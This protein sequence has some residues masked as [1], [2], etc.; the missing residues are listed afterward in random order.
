YLADRGFEKVRGSLTRRPVVR[1]SDPADPNG[2]PVEQRLR[3]KK[4]NSLPADFDPAGSHDP[5][6]KIELAREFRAAVGELD[7][8]DLERAI[9]E[10]HYDH[11]LTLKEVAKKVG[12]SEEAAFKAHQRLKAKIKERLSEFDPK[13]PSD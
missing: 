10:G 2:P 6:Q 9:V 4:F 1:K 5:D 12:V 3:I 7:L 8:S 11:G 13:T